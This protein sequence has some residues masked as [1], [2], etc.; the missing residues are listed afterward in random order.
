MVITESLRGKAVRVSV[1][2]QG[3]DCKPCMRDEPDAMATSG[4]GLF[5][6]ETLSDRW[7]VDEH[8]NGREVWFEVAWQ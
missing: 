4:R 1:I 7:G 2:D 6:V 8:P 5:L 3:S